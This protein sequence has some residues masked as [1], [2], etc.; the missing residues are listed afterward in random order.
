MIFPIDPSLINIVREVRGTDK[1]GTLMESMQL[2][3]ALYNKF[4][5]SIESMLSTLEK[6]FS[7]TRKKDN[8]DIRTLMDRINLLSSGM[9]YED[10]SAKSVPEQN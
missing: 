5:V 10:K 6:N 4:Y 3:Q 8:E 7:A 2:R 9:V 1:L